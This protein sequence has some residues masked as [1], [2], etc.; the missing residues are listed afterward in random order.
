MEKYA[1]RGRIARRKITL[2][3]ENWN[4][5]MMIKV[6]RGG[7]YHDSNDAKIITMQSKEK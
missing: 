3:N 6:G 4:E 5:V 1:E 7:V 2:E